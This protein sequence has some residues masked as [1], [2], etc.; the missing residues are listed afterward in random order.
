MS[1]QIQ[2]EDIY[3][4]IEMNQLLINSKSD[5][6]R[7]ITIQRIS[8]TDPHK[9]TQIENYLVLPKEDIKIRIYDVIEEYINIELSNKNRTYTEPEFEEDNKRNEDYAKKLLS[10][11]KVELEQNKFFTENSMFKTPI[12]SIDIKY[13]MS[14]VLFYVE[15]Y[16]SY[17]FHGYITIHDFGIVGKTPVKLNI[18]EH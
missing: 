10:V 5:N 17:D 11:L 8:K 2:C 15:N 7:L 13:H 14:G 4:S 1:S 3:F 9:E 6:H 16:T 12:E 18:F